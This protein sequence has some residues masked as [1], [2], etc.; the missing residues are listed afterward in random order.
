MDMTVSGAFPSKYLRP[1][2]LGGRDVTVTIEEVVFEKV[3]R[4]NQFVVYFHGKRK[5]F[6]I[7]SA[8]ANQIKRALGN[9]DK[10]ANWAGQKITLYEAKNN[11]GRDVIYVREQGAVDATRHQERGEA[12]SAGASTGRPNFDR[13]PAPQAQRQQQVEEEP[14]LTDDDIPF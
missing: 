4:D 7:Y 9:E 13:A 5:G 8:Q 2:D 1:E 10:M 11:N 6:V 12:V 14:P 3:G